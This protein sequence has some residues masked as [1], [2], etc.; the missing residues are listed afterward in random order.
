MC[1][2]QLQQALG[3]KNFGKN[4]STIRLLLCMQVARL[5]LQYKPAVLQHELLQN[6]P[7][8]GSTRGKVQSPVRL[9]HNSLFIIH[10][11]FSVSGK[12]L[13]GFKQRDKA[14]AM[15]PC[16]FGCARVSRISGAPARV[17]KDLKAPPAPP[18][19]QGSYMR[20]K[21]I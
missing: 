16:R 15:W 11:L 6:I 17:P 14:Q 20:L 2:P 10:L 1:P 8:P 18:P 5:K 7:Q 3:K 12:L 13:G 21:S 9:F 19:P 4:E